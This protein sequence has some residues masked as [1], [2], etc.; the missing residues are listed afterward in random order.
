MPGAVQVVHG[1]MFS[2]PADLI[3]MP[4]ST[5]GTVTSFVRER[6]QRFALPP[7]PRGIRL[8]EVRRLPLTGADHVAQFVAYAASVQHAGSSLEAIE[9]IGEELGRATHNDSIQV[10]HCPLLGAGAGHLQ[11]EKVVARLRQ[12]FLDKCKDGSLLKV[13]VLHENVYERLVRQ[14]M[15]EAQTL[16]EAALVPSPSLSPDKQRLTSGRIPPRV[17]ISYTS[18]SPGTQQWVEALYEFLSHNNINARLDSRSLRLGMD[19][20]QWMC[21]ELDLADRVILVCDEEYAARADRRHGGVGWETMIV[22]G[23]MYADGYRAQSQD[24]P[25]KYIPVVRSRDRDAGLPAYLRTKLVLH[26]P[27]GQAEDEPRRRL[28][29]EILHD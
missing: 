26:W 28:L 2:G 7:A 29:G 25:A 4:C 15:T 17:F 8:G 1:D 9:R 12:G 21:N 6:M 10:V 22:Q 18:G 19:V 14:S 16:A 11:S 20:V 23:D 13:F 24:T 27:P 3:V 5:A